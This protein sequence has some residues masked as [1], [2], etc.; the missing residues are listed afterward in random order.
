MTK[1]TCLM[2]LIIAL[3]GLPVITGGI[4][5]STGDALK[6]QHILKTIEAG[7]HSAGQKAVRSA[8]ITEKELN[9]YIAY[10]L[11]QEKSPIIRGLHVILGNSNRV[12]GNIRFD[13]GSA[14]LLGLLG[15]DLHFDFDGTLQTQDGAGRL[16]LTSLLLN[17]EPVP[18]ETLG[19]V[20]MAVARY[21]GTEPGRVDDW[22]ELPQGVQRIDVQMAKAILYY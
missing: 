21:Y 16:D 19:P 22:Y 11:N 12:R 9:A 8:V 10:R 13:L 5:S 7:S 20:L 4:D 15:S 18:P 3:F 6:V 14:S 17:G 2:A 1:Y